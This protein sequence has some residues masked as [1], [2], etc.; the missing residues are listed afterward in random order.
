MRMEG[1]A[2]N[3]L[4]SEIRIFKPKEVRLEDLIGK[5]I[6]NFQSD[7]ESFDVVLEDDFILEVY[8]GGEVKGGKVKALKMLF[9]SEV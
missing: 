8:W 9:K 6:V 1:F 4:K 3:A 7:S 2:L 5:K